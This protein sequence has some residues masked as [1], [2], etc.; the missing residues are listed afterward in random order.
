MFDSTRDFFSLAY[1]FWNWNIKGW[2]FKTININMYQQWRT[3]GIQAQPISTPELL[4]CTDCLNVTKQIDNSNDQS[5][6]Q[7]VDLDLVQEHWVVT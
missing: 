3:K 5:K 7:I 2:L 1:C 6:Q 4:C